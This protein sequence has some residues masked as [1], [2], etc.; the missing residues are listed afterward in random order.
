MQS[1]DRSYIHPDLASSPDLEHYTGLSIAPIH[2]ALEMPDNGLAVAPNAVDL[3]KVL[4][5]VGQG[6]PPSPR[7][8]VSFNIIVILLVNNPNDWIHMLNS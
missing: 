8:I 1:V 3:C 5:L 7:K 2:D 6:H 4:N